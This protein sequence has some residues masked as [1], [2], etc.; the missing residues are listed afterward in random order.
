MANVIED[1]T[2]LEECMTRVSTRLV[3]RECVSMTYCML[4]LEHL[5]D[6]KLVAV[7]SK[8][9]DSKNCNAC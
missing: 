4:L 8:E 6:E 9:T 1:P 3:S 2:L 7:W 5:R